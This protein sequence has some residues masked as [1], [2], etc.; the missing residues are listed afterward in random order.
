MDAVSTLPLEN[1]AR[2]EH[3]LVA[4]AT[5][6]SEAAGKRQTLIVIRQQEKRPDKCLA[7]LLKTRCWQD[8]K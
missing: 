1:I 8:G 5:L 6:G 4:Y 7:F 3:E 2:Y